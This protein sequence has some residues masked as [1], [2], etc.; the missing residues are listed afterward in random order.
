MFQEFKDFIVKG[1][2]FD[3]AVGVIIGGVFG[4]VVTSLVGDILM[5]PIGSILGGADF[6]NLFA[7]LKEGAA[8]GPYASLAAAKEAGAV[9]LNYGAFINTLV[10]LVIVGFVIFMLVKGVNAA[11]KPAPAAPAPTPEDVVLLREIRDALRK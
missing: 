2:A 6:S 11:R 3:L 7:T 9:T 1:N 8:P 5:P 4:A 10:N